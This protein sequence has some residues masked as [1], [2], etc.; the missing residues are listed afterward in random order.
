MDWLDLAVDFFHRLL[1]RFS[2]IAYVSLFVFLI[3]YFFTVFKICLKLS[4]ITRYK[5]KSMK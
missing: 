1:V 3:F 2:Y 5:E 4:V